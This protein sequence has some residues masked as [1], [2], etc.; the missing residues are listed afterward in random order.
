V[1]EIFS[2]TERSHFD[3]K[4]KVR[5]RKRTLQL[6]KRVANSD[7]DFRVVALPPRSG[8]QRPEAVT[9]SIDCIRCEAASFSPMCSSIKTA[10][11]IA[12]I[13]LAIPFPVMSKAEP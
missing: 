12:P 13:G 9:R 6:P 8:V 10:V 5:F 3:E 4:A 1:N 7:G 11:Q 2:C